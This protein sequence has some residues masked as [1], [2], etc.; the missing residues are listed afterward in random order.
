MCCHPVNCLTS[1][2]WE[3]GQGVPDGVTGQTFG[4][5]CV[6]AAVRQLGDDGTHLRAPDLAGGEPTTDVDKVGPA[7][8]FGHLI[9]RGPQPVVFGDQ[10]S[11]VR[12]IRDPEFLGMR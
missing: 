6:E 5:E 12:H 10:R 9:V 11:Y 3:T 7:E 1:A 2:A 4:Q 8:R